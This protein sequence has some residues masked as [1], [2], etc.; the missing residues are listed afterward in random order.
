MSLTL[1][2]VY[3]RLLAEHGPQGWWPAETPFE[4]MVGAILTQ[5]T[6][7]TNV[8]RAIEALKARQWLSAEMLVQR[9][10]AELAEVLRPVGYFN[11]KT[12]RLQAFCHWYLEMGGYPVLETW[13]TPAL[14]GAL[15]GVTG[16][17]PETADDIVLYAFERPVFVIDAYTRRLFGRLGLGPADPDRAAYDTWRDYF[18]RHLPSDAGLFNEYH[19]LI[20]KQGK[21]ICRPKPYCSACALRASCAFAGDCP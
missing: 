6:A 4:V 12:R 18:E 11:V 16:V 21:D 5:N 1:Q 15:L 14:R 13:P 10:H 20:V 17:G 8:E 3:D 19:A 9:E 2:N 7:W